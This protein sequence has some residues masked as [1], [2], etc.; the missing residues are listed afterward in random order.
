MKNYSNHYLRILDEINP[1]SGYIPSKVEYVAWYKKHYKTIAKQT[2]SDF[3]M[4]ELI[5]AFQEFKNLVSFLEHEQTIIEANNKYKL[6]DQENDEEVIEWLIDYE[7]VYQYAE[8]F[9]CSHFEWEEGKIEGNKIIVSKELEIKIELSDFKE[10]IVFEKTF[11][12]LL[13]KYKN[14]LQ[15]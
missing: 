5:W 1:T 6:L 2:Y 11:R 7:N 15:K 10:F 3:C 14:E 9:Y 13:T 12:P 4:Q 8:H